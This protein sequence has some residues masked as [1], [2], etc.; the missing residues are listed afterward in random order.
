VNPIEQFETTINQHFKPLAERLTLRF[1]RFDDHLFVL[2][3]A[4]I[5]VHVYFFE[6]FSTPG[7]DVVVG[8]APQ[9]ESRWNPPGERG[10]GWFTKYLGIA[11]M[12][13]GRITTVTEIS[14]RVQVLSEITDD[15]LER[16]FSVGQEFWP[17]FYVFVQGE[18]AKIPEPAWIHDYKKT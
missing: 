5:S 13:E 8:I 14:Q 4:D 11:G 1:G 2:Y 16:V 3:A 10:L 6:P 18:I 17:P 15:T 7:Y 9:H 12:P